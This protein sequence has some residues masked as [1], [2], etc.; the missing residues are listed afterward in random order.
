MSYDHLPLEERIQ[1]A[2]EYSL[3]LSQ[4]QRPQEDI[5]AELQQMFGLEKEQAVQAIGLMRR[6]YSGEYNK[7]YREGIIMALGS[8]FAGIVMGLAY[9]FIGQEGGSFFLFFAILFGL[10]GLGALLVIWQKTGERFFFSERELLV[11]VK[12]RYVS[13]DDLP[14]E[15]AKKG[16]WTTYFLAFS[17]IG[18]LGAWYNFYT[19]PRYI[20][21]RSVVRVDSLVVEGMISEK[22]KRGDDYFIFRFRGYPQS[23]RFYGSYYKYADGAITPDQYPPGSVLGIELARGDSVRMSNREGNA[24]DILNLVVKGR[25][26]YS[27]KLRNK[28]EKDNTEGFLALTIIVFVLAIG[29]KIIFGQKKKVKAV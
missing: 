5:A 4:D 21:V 29:S 28:T 12:N 20:D 18:L 9:F 27:Y 3:L 22:V 14:D 15:P 7:S 6:Q 19:Q 23:F 2:A 11:R 26:L 17:L 13:P 24:I 25:R 16:A 10:S 8:L 1:K